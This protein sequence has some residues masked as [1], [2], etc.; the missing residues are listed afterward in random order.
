MLPWLQLRWRLGKN[1]KRPFLAPSSGL[2]ACHLRLGED[3]M[4]S[5]ILLCQ[6]LQKAAC[7]NY[8]AGMRMLEDAAGSG[9]APAQSP[10]KELYN[11]PQNA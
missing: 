7:G 2:L 6:P 4:V 9:S 1:P 3:G 8:R 11:A 5:G 10:A